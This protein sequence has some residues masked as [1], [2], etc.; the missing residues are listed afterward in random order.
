MLAMQYISTPRGDL[1]I[2]NYYAFD[3]VHP[4]PFKHRH[5]YSEDSLS[6]SCLSKVY[7]VSIWLHQNT[8]ECSRDKHATIHVI[9]TSQSIKHSA[10]ILKHTIKIKIQLLWRASYTKPASHRVYI[11]I[12]H[13]HVSYI[14]VMNRTIKPC[15]DLFTK[16]RC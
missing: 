16:D 5:L 15:V 13:K 7:K 1:P 9:A 2:T 6:S 4:N 3:H 8:H 14:R 10:Y 11:L 12:A